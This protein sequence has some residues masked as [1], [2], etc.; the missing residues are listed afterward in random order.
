MKV[1][2]KEYETERLFNKS[3]KSK[4]DIFKQVYTLNDPVIQSA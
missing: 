4:F 3:D 2:L 1:S